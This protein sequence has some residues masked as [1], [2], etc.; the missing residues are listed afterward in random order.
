MGIKAGFPSIV[1][2]SD[3]M[4][5]YCLFSGTVDFKPGHWVGVKY[6]EPLGKH[7]GRLVLAQVIYV[8]E[9]DQHVSE[10]F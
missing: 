8:Y 9:E 6:D 3:H 5:V 7:D 10:M 2:S 1:S 4:P